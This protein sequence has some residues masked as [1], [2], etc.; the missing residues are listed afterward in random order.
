[1][2]IAIPE[3]GSVH[4][5]VSSINNEPIGWCH[6]GSSP[7]SHRPLCSPSLTHACERARSGT[8]T[9][10]SPGGGSGCSGSCWKSGWDNHAC[11]APGV[12]AAAVAGSGLDL[13]RRVGLVPDWSPTGTSCR[14]YWAF[15]ERRGR[16]PR[17]ELLQFFERSRPFS[18]MDE[19]INRYWSAALVWNN[20]V[21]G[22]GDRSITEEDIE[23]TLHLFL[24]PYV[25][26]K[27]WIERETHLGERITLHR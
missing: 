19:R 15:R 24:R 26:S 25:F 12:D 10:T 4:L 20:L 13:G 6:K 1:M 3:A 5:Q 18:P 7:L 23:G 2:K 16:W 8:C 11:L 9:R 17:K 14:G 27:T 22:R 21:S